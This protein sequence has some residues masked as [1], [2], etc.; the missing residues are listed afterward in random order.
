[1]SETRQELRPWG[2]SSIGDL[3]FESGAYCARYV[4]KKVT[5]RQGED[6]YLRHDEYGVANWLEP[7]Y[8]TM[9][10]GG[11]G[12][13]GGIGKEWYDKYKDDVFPSD[14][15]P[16]EG[17]GIL[18]KVPRY[19]EK[20]LREEDEAMFDRVKDKRQRYLKDHI[21][22]FSPQRLEDKYIV[23]RARFSLKGRRFEDDSEYL[24]DL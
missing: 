3:T 14:E 2:F 16:V 4:V 11:R 13:L 17:V 19:Y 18:N 12:G 24:H 1:M 7:E 10:R 21:E 23:A 9:S 15:L 20:I 5:G 6:H 8:S 22:D